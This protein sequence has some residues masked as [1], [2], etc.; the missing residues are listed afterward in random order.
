MCIRDSPGAAPS[1]APSKAPI[2]AASVEPALRQAHT[3][4]PKAVPAAEVD[5]KLLVEELDKYKLQNDKL[6]GVVTGLKEDL[7]A[8]QEKLL[9]V[10]DHAK[11]KLKTIKDLGTTADE[12]QALKMLEGNRC[13]GIAV[14]KVQAT[15]ECLKKTLPELPETAQNLM[16]LVG[17][18][19]HELETANEEL[20]DLAFLSKKKLEEAY[21]QLGTQV[22]GVMEALE[23]EE[24]RFLQR[25]AVERGT[26]SLQPVA[27]I[28]E[29][30]AA[31]KILEYLLKMWAQSHTFRG[32]YTWRQNMSATGS[33]SKLCVGMVRQLW[34]RVAQSSLQE[35][36][37]DVL[38]G[39]S[40]AIRHDILQSSL[41]GESEYLMMLEIKLAAAL[42][43]EAGCGGGVKDRVERLVE[44]VAQL[45]STLEADRVD[46]QTVD[47]LKIARLEESNAA[48]TQ[49][50]NAKEWKIQELS[51]WVQELSATKAV[52]VSYTHLTL[53]T[54]RIV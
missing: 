17:D 9:H 48:A 44:C 45:Q 24:T 2:N 4:A 21:A 34:E 54:K 14:Q 19:V 1:A 25:R 15:F 22:P 47:E 42:N 50:L 39:E 20:H 30:Q 35:Q 12:A 18:R 49:E 51:K 6:R 28:G 10:K 52:P 41:K 5:L 31:L 53:P 43:M 29:E 3:D 16:K 33:P 11:T 40:W 46:G 7:H 37:E 13:R 8:S 38:D 27:G 32:L 23:A 26:L 36:G